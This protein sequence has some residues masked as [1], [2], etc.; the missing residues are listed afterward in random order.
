MNNKKAQSLSM[1]TV[2]IGILVVVVLVVII[3]F[4]V[5]GTSTTITKIK[6]VFRGAS[7][8]DLAQAKI[9]CENWCQDAKLFTSVDEKKTSAYCV[10]SFKIDVDGDGIAEKIS[11]GDNQGEFLKYYCGPNIHTNDQYNAQGSPTDNKGINNVG[12]S[13][14]GVSENCNQ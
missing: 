10:Q 14:A 1:N 4:F 3:A 12:V 6:N 7:G 2:I 8:T 5:Y 13:C 9:S 11:R